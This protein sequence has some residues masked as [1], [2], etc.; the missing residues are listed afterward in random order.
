MRP[1]GFKRATLHDYAARMGL[2]PADLGDI[3]GTAFFI[4]KMDT[5]TISERTGIP[6]PFVA[7]ALHAWREQGRAP[8]ETIP[9]R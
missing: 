8:S 3:F 2:A 4:E 9:R 1:C 6:E 7:N 5:A